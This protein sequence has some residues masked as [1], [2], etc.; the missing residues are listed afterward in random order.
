MTTTQKYVVFSCNERH[1]A[2]LRPAQI[3]FYCSR[4]IQAQPVDAEVQ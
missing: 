1:Y 2:I 4:V 3:H